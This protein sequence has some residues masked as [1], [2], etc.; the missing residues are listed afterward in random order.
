MARATVGS[1]RGGRRPKPSLNSKLTKFARAV[2]G[3]VGASIIE[4]VGGPKAKA[5]GRVVKTSA[6]LARAIAR[7]AAGDK[8]KGMTVRKVPLYKLDKAKV[9]VKT[10]SSTTVK[11]GTSAQNAPKTKSQVAER[12]KIVIKKMTAAEKTAAK[13]ASKARKEAPASRREAT[14]PNTVGVKKYTPRATKTVRRARSVNELGKSTASRTEKKIAAKKERKLEARKN[15]ANRPSVIARNKSVVRRAGEQKQAEKKRQL[16][17]TRL[18]NDKTPVK[19]YGP[20]GKEQGR[21]IGITTKGELRQLKIK[22][23][24]AARDPEN[25]LRGKPQRTIDERSP[26]PQGL[27]DKEIEILRKVGKRDYSRGEVNPLAQRIVQSEAD[28]RVGV[29]F[30]DPRVTAQDKARETAAIRKTMKDAKTSRGIKNMRKNYR[31]KPMN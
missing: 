28:K 30:K 15:R 22:V 17:E 4:G 13:A 29:F 14:K 3:I 2:P 27:T 18:L 24:R 11:K 16:N 1:G 9:T 26:R 20:G 31:G 21:V 12:N 25:S 6:K 10:G 7:E 23:D 19:Q 8:A 5:A